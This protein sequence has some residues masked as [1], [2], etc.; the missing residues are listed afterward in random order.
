MNQLI[1]I[2]DRRQVTIPK[3]FLREF[4]LGVGDKFIIKLESDQISLEPLKVKTVD[5][6]SKIQQVIK[7][8]GI[9]EKE[10]EKTSVGLKN[11]QSKYMSSSQQ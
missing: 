9:S 10:L 6:L 11:K 8:T 2:R 1:S 5:L 4:G 3:A 7:E